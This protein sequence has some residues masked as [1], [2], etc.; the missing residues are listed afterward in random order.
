[1]YIVKLLIL[2]KTVVFRKFKNSQNFIPQFYLKIFWVF[3]LNRI[4][5]NTLKQGQEKQRTRT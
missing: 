3:M 5:R 2:L 4:H 1:M